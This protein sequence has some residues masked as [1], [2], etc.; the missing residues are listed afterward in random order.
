M[1]HIAGLGLLWGWL[2]PG[3]VTCWFLY[4]LIGFKL[5]SDEDTEN[6]F[7]DRFFYALAFTFWPPFALI[8]LI[9][10]LDRLNKDLNK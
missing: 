9:E 5:P 1:I 6:D 4:E 2:I 8:L 7:D 3:G 10:W